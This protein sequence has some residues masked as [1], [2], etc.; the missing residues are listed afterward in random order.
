MKRALA[1]AFLVTLAGVGA[2][3]S[4]P[5][6]ADVEKGYFDAIDAWKAFERRT[7][8]PKAQRAI[9][10]AFAEY[11]PEFLNGDT[12]WNNSPR[13]RRDS[14]LICYL[15][16]LRDRFPS[17]EG[18][19]SIHQNQAPPEN[20]ELELEDGGTYDITRYDIARYTV[21]TFMR[22]DIRP[23]L[24]GHNG[25]LVVAP[26]EVPSILMVDGYDIGRATTILVELAG[27]HRIEVRSQTRRCDVKVV[28]VDGASVTLACP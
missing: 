15:D 11:D 23:V 21:E 13:T 24:A 10:F 12:T 20:R 1:I 3:Q 16:R 28:V 26:N 25:E 7:V 2:M 8:S 14:F 4:T 9:A 17:F 5:Q 6:A 27:E 18:V 22:E 19:G